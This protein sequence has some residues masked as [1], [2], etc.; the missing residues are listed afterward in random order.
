MIPS[1]P[2]HIPVIDISPSRGGD[3]GDRLGVA[4][5]LGDALEQVGFATVVGHG[6][7]EDFLGSTY[8]ALR[9][10]FALP[11]DEKMRACPPEKAK[12]RGYLPLGIE[13]V[14]A[15]LDADTPPD[16]CEALVFSALARPP[17]QRPTIWPEHPTG[18]RDMVLRY[19]RELDAL[20]KH[21]G[22]LAALA[23][24]L[25]E[26]DLDGYFADPSMT[27]R[28]VNYPDQPAA[29]LPGQ[30]RYGAHHDY[31]GLTIL[32]QD[33]A[34]GGLEVCDAGG[35]WHEVPASPGGFVINV[36]DLM[37]RWTNGRWRSTLHRVVNP[38]RALTGSTQRLSMVTFFSPNEESEI[39]CLPSCATS[40]NP[41]QW[42]PVKAGEYIRAK[43]ARSMELPPVPAA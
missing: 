28:F 9:A 7:S 38:D 3:P 15:T 22:R 12:S 8:A 33:E 20:G 2:F 30:L 35:T 16:L 1:V 21:L 19:S 37:S 18:L 27:L 39:A 24:D 29:P 11:M 41:A 42:A 5:A 13:S 25:S 34:P 17:S 6:I 23:L 31:G 32:R 10:F 14:A 4:R 26:H 40:T 36:G 43:I